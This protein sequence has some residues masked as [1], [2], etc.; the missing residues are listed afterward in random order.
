MVLTTSC[1]GE[2]AVI[3]PHCMSSL[4]WIFLCD[5]DRVTE[6]G[7]VLLIP[8]AQWAPLVDV[9]GR[10]TNSDVCCYDYPPRV[11]LLSLT[12]IEFRNASQVEIDLLCSTSTECFIADCWKAPLSTLL[13]ATVSY[14]V[15][16]FHIDV[17]A[18]IH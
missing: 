2:V 18:R 4:S 10:G 16:V 7:S 12:L 14:Q 5:A 3:A 6:D 11:S 17:H 1:L 9:T 15:C 8:S 13:S